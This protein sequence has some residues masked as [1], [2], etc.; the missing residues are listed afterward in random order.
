M[1]PTT[2]ITMTTEARD[3]MTEEPAI[4]HHLIQGNMVGL[5]LRQLIRVYQTREPGRQPGFLFN[6]R[7]EDA[8]LFIL[9][10]YQV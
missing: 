9:I 4:R 6:T 1:L 2:G 3:I 5:L 8:C 7:L 10:R